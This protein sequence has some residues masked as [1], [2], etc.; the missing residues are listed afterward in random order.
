MESRKS[1]GRRPHNARWLKLGLAVAGALG[2]MG[3]RV[4]AQK[5]PDETQKSLQVA[6]GL[7][8]S[9]FA[10][11]PMFANPCDM[12][13]DAK[14]R[15][16]VS[17]GWNYR[18]S[19]LRPNEGDR[20]MI[21][22]DTDGDGRA[23]K[24][25]TF[26]QGTDVNSA[27]GVCV[28]GNRV[29][30]SCAPNVL[31]LT[32]EDGDGKAD[33]KEVLFP[34]ISGVQHDHAIHAFSF[35]P[36]GKVYFNFGNEGKQLKDKDGRP[37][38]DVRGNEVNAKG[39]PY[40]QGMVFRMNPDGTGVE[41][42]AW[43]FRNNYEVAVDSFGTLWQ[44]D[45]D[46][47]GNRGVRINYVMEGGNFG[48]TDE[49]TGANWGEQ[50]R[51]AQS[52]G[53]SETDKVNWEWHQYDPGVV[54]NLL[55]TGQ[56]SPTGICVYE[57][58]LLPRQF[59]G[60]MIHADAGPNVVRAYPVTPDGAGFKAETVNILQGGSDKWFRPSDVCVAPDGSLMVAD[61]YDP[62]VGGHQTG[63]KN[64][65]TLIKG[66]VYRVAPTGSKYQVPKLDLTT[67]AGAVAA[68]TNPN[69]ATRY[70]AWTKL[71]ELGPAAEAELLKLWDD[72]SEPRL[73]ARALHL[74]ARTKGLGEKYVNAGLADADANIRITA[75]RIARDLKMDVPAI[76]KRVVGDSSAQ[77][78]REAAI[79]LRDQKSPEA[80]TLWAELASRH[81]PGDRW[82]TEALGIAATGRDDEFFDAYLRKVGENGWDTPAGRDVVWRVRSERCAPL[83]AKIILDKGTPPERLWQLFRA[84]DFLK[85][86]AKD[87]AL[88]QLLDNAG[89]NRTVIVESLARMKNIE[90]AKAAQVKQ[91]VAKLIDAARGT[92]EFVQLVEQFDLRDRDADLLAYAADKPTEAAAGTAIRLVVKNDPAALERAM[93]GPQGAKLAVALGASTD[94][95]VIQLLSTIAGDA[96]RDLAVRQAAVTALTRSRQGAT[97]VLGLA[98]KKLLG[99][100]VAPLAASLLHNSSNKGVRDEAA[101]LLP[102]PTAKGSEQMPPLEKLVGM[103]GNAA[104]GKEVF[105]S[106]TCATCHVINGEGTNFGP[107]LSEI[108]AKLPKDALYTSILYPS[109][110]ISFGYEGWILSTKDG[111]DLDGMVASETADRIVLKRAGGINT[112]IKKADVKDRRQMKLSIMPENLQQQMSTQDLVDLVE[113]LS[114]LKKAEQRAGK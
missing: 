54:P 44:S 112:E 94:R 24:P 29:I 63:D 23:D 90:P 19:R 70:L 108:G 78:R 100:D 79:A 30:V 21:L 39:Q 1:D 104:H 14:G 86:P 113:Y 15:V 85:G 55:H 66:R 32:D 10:S 26:Y 45:N 38:V 84:F 65:Q 111:D 96:K 43:N 56:G 40:R 51:T 48:Y 27:L 60:Q 74:L 11:E 61:W 37:I 97:A 8:V 53:A 31:L 22:E 89:D 88:A 110:G 12:D 33:K 6:E 17:E 52:K 72:K 93:A 47:D 71:H 59:W 75:L 76:V 103:K 109:A 81:T 2:A 77:V 58:K 3:N 114:T 107:E 80:A 57:G 7:E 73:R 67:A 92:A 18:G 87:A 64:V 50:W 35:G 34:G 95:N 42:L 69:N 83:L 25:T 41:T 102:L 68:L 101:K 82:E 36:D 91:R 62:G 105:V 106:A 5:S 20:I 28:L 9:V 99:Q 16:W 98:A 4:W 46:D 49:L 13:V